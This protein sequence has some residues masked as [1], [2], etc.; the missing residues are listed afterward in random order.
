M[1]TRA[2]YIW[3]IVALVGVGAIAF[4]ALT[5]GTN[6]FTAV[7]IG[8]IVV[9]VAKLFQAHGNPMLGIV[10]MATG[11]GLWVG[12]DLFPSLTLADAASLVGVD[13]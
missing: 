8:L 10:L 5:L 12:H 13:A 7:G 11:T 2:L 1:N 4:G 3:G 6:L 9:G